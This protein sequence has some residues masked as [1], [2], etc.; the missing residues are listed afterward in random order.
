MPGGG[1]SLY[2][3]WISGGNPSEGKKGPARTEAREKIEK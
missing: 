3:L 1:D 2:D